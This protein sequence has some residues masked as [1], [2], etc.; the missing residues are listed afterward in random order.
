MPSLLNG[1]DT[2]VPSGKFCKPIPIAKATAAPN[3][4]E[5]N[6]CATA[7]KATPTARPSGILCKV[8]AETNKT[9]RFQLE[10]GPSASSFL[11]PV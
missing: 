5:G 10:E 1:T 11:N 4:A 2:E 9:L 7:P 6:P 3:V 8:I